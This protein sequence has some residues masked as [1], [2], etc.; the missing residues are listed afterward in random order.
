MD[1]SIIL[2]KNID[3]IFD[4]YNESTFVLDREYLDYNIGLRGTF[5]LYIPRKYYYDKALYLIN[6]YDKLFKLNKHNRGIDEFILYFTIYPNWSKKLF[7]PLMGC[8]EF[9][10]K[11]LDCDLYYYQINKPFIN[12]IDNRHNNPKK[13]ETWDLIIKELI[14]KYPELTNVYKYIKEYRETKF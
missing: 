5:Y 11:K 8:Y 12:N 9:K 6:N 3:Y 13:Y 1:S 2:R 10:K 4:K 7:D 14:E